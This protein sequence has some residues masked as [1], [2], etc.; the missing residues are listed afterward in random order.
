VFRPQEP[1]CRVG[2][3]TRVPVFRDEHREP[4]F[5]PLVQSRDDQRQRRLGHP[6]TLGERI[7]EGLE[8][9]GLSQDADERVQYGPV[10]DDRRNR[11]VPPPPMLLSYFVSTGAGSAAPVTSSVMRSA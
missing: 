4:A 11:P 3:V 2:E 9:L 7:R 10:H 8:T 1:A 5:E 6:S